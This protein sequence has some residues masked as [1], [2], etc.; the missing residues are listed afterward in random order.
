MGKKESPPPP[1][2]TGLDADNPRL[3]NRSSFFCVL[4]HQGDQAAWQKQLFDVVDV[5]GGSN[6][7]SELIND[8][9]HIDSVRD[10]LIAV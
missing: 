9:G 6:L 5:L 1:T 7:Q 10:G 8:V 4:T 2:G 3:F